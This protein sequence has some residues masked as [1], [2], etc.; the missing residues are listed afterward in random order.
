MS[1]AVDYWF[2]LFHDQG[3]PGKR[4]EAQK[5]IHALEQTLTTEEQVE[6]EHCWE[7]WHEAMTASL[8]ADSDEG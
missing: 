1:A 6:I 7:D 4:D 8:T 5:K 2:E 3:D